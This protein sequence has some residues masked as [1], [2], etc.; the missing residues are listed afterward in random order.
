M[1]IPDITN[2]TELQSFLD[3]V[4][5]KLRLIGEES[6]ELSFQ[7]YLDKQPNPRIAELAGERSQI[8]LDPALRALVD[9]WYPRCE[10]PLLK[11]RLQL[12]QRSLVAGQV[13]SHPEIRALQ[14]D[15]DQRMVAHRYLYRGE[16]VSLGA[17]RNTVRFDR[18]AE[19]R[20]EAWLSYRELSQQ[21][22]P[23][24]LRLIKLRNQVSQQLGFQNYVDLIL[25]HNEMSEEQ[26]V[27][28]L[29][30][31][32]EKSQDKYEDVLRKGA[33]NLGIESI[34]PWD[35]QICL[36]AGEAAPPSYFPKDG[37]KPAVA[38]WAKTMGV[39]IEEL[40]IEYVFVDIPYNG[41][42][43]G[44]KKGMTKILGNPQDG[45]AYYKTM[46]HELGHALHGA[47]NEI[48]T[49]M[50]KRDSGIFTE[51]LAEVFGYVAATPEWLAGR[52][53][54]PGIAEKAM[55]STIG[56]T[57]HYL[58]QRSA[59]CLFEYEMYR[60]PDLDLDSLMA[61]WDEQV[62]GCR[63]D[64]TSRWAAN[65]WFI[66]YPVYWQNYVLADVMASQ[67]H[68]HLNRSF[69]PLVTSKEAFDFVISHYIAPG[70]ITSWLW[71]IEEATGEPLN[72]KA[73]IEDLNR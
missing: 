45:F 56:P 40:G 39:D 55:A 59:Y 22:A 38:A 73:L 6:G 37:I 28:I 44:I 14:Q 65:A 10:E 53:L 26:V 4:E 58:R 35:V 15:L 25:S 12:W 68:H 60:N 50:L 9:T 49:P 34:E 23:D 8:M 30:E 64:A 36:E 52:N 20:K 57:F 43:M 32:L 29:N 13:L 42:C 24:L 3:Q 66:S 21:L 31:L 1:T 33:K 11:R 46:F 67:V 18:D 63:Y 72:P 62:L 41:L 48:E 71:K 69:G 2:P 16:R 5:D 51:G 54:P 27:G 17:I 19:A 47:L 70:A 61:R 7:R